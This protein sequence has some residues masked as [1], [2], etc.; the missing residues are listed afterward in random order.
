MKKVLGANRRYFNQV[1]KGGPH[2]EAANRVLA[3]LGYVRGK[4][5]KGS[6]LDEV[7][8]MNSVRSALLSRIQSAIIGAASFALLLE[9]LKEMFSRGLL[10]R[11][12]QRNASEVFVR[13]DRATQNYYSRRLGLIHALYAGTIKNNTRAFCRARVQGVY[14]RDEIT[15]WQ[16]QEWQGKIPG[17]DVK[18]VLG[19]YNCRHH[20]SWITPEIA[21]ALGPINTYRE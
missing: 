4:I 1:R 13:S 20:L 15:K 16:D 18:V 8:R 6:W 14:T 11:F 21:E 2:E 12:F 3:G 10:R 7:S 9:G 17:A 19:G 5:K